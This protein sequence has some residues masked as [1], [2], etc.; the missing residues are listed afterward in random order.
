MGSQWE[1]YFSKM[2]GSQREKI[3]D[4]LVS[5]KLG[6]REW[7]DIKPLK[8]YDAIWRCRTWKYRI[9]FEKKWTNYIL[10]K[11]LPRWDIYK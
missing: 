1:K 5:I 4:I 11:I 10:L 7:L 9:L 8:W 6:N 3:K 2:N